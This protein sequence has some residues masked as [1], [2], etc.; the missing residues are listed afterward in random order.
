MHV[1]AGKPRYAAVNF[2]RYRVCADSCL[3]R[4]ISFVTVVMAALK[5]CKYIVILRISATKTLVLLRGILRS[6]ILA[7][8]DTSCMTLYRLYFPS[9]QRYCELP[10]ASFSYPILAKIQGCFIWRRS[11][12]LGSA[13]SE[14]PRLI[15]TR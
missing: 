7:P 13:K 2:D 1:V 14:D 6:Y 10:T 5:S 15:M 11:I 3:F 9:F 8:N 12:M 4:S